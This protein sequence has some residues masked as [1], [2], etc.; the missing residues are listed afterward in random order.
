M[1]ENKI[2]YAIIAVLFVLLSAGIIFG[3]QSG[4]LC[5]FGINSIAV[6]CPLGSLLAMIAARTLIPRAVINLV[7]VLVLVFVLGRAFCGWICPTT[8]WNKIKAYFAPKKKAAAGAQAREE[9][10]RAIGQAEIDRVMAEAKAAC[11][12]GC[13]SCGAGGCPAKRKA[14]DSRH[15]VL[16][17]A[18]LS[19]AI[20]G[21]PVFCL[22]CPIGLSF[23]TI[24]LLLASS[25]SAT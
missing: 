7:I 23:A 4:T 12:E 21:F 5:G 11:G 2:R 24:V 9:A 10:A 8:L 19:T 3:V 13:A 22:V 15:A 18:I 6:L 25:A 1:K 14:L 20:F 17:G 16:G